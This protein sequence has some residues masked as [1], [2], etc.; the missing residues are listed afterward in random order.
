LSTQACS[1]ESSLTR[2]AQEFLI[3]ARPNAGA[4]RLRPAVAAAEC[5]VLLLAAL[6][7]WWILGKAAPSP[8]NDSG[9]KP[10]PADGIGQ[11]LPGIRGN[12]PRG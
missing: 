10:T 7:L 12:S 8:E 11:L 1:A 4:R 2:L 9:A 3:P 6:I 5:I